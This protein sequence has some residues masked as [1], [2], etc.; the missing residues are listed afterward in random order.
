LT[1]DRLTEELASPPLP[2]TVSLIVVMII[3]S[4]AM[5]TVSTMPA[6]LAVPAMLTMPATRAA[7]WCGN[8]I[9]IQGNRTVES[10]GPAI[11]N[12]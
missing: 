9:G 5:V 12:G 1:A 6:M 8:G 2:V 10:H 3:I 7:G 4:V 11:R